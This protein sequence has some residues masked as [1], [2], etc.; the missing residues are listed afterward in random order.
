M[1]EPGHNRNRSDSI[2]RVEEAALDGCPLLTL[3]NG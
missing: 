1:V 3:M 2:R